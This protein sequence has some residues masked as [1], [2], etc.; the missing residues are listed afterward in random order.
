MKGGSMRT[1]GVFV[2]LFVLISASLLA[3]PD[4][5]ASTAAPTITVKDSTY[6]RIFFAGSNHVV[7]AFTHDPRDK[8]TCYRECARRW[9]PYVVH[10]AI[11][12]GAGSRR[13]L[14]GTIRRRDGSRQ[15]TYAGRPLYFYVGDGPGQVKCQNVREFGGLWLVVRASGRLVR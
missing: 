11:R 8:A 12:A 6:G 4:L 1:R 9:P 3:T 2:F 5:A 10:G 14:L 7:Y 13:S 15:L